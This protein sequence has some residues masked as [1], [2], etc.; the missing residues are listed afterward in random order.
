MK[1]INSHLQ[2]RELLQS[3]EGAKYDTNCYIFDDEFVRLID[4]KL[5]FFDLH[6]S[7]LL[8]YKLNESFDFFEV[9]YY[10]VDNG[11]NIDIVDSGNFVMEIPY[12][13]PKNF[14]SVM[15]DF[16]NKAG[17]ST[18]IDRELL[19]LSK[20][21]SESFIFAESEFEY[22]FIDDL[23]FSNLIYDSI[24]NTFDQF[25]GDILTLEEVGVFIK[26]NNFLG[27]Y[28][29]EELAGFIRFY[30]KNSIAWASHLV[31]MSEYRGKGIA[32]DLFLHYL[33]MRADQGFTNFQH[34]VGTDNHAAKKLYHNLGYKATNKNSISLLK[35]II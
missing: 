9:Y 18:H 27:A 25:T 35:Q 5:L 32:N 30:E 19:R 13:G 31:V 16:W 10:I 33:K 4:A 20:P 24:K 15:V 12:R 21:D 14:P 29:G 6:G 17:F 7:N 34:W 26:N 2:L 28:D 23:K 1:K 11:R 3:F 8:L 22:K